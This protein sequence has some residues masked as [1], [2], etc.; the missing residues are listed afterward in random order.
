ML[1]PQ[2]LFTYVIMYFQNGNERKKE[3]AG[4]DTFQIN[5]QSSDETNNYYTQDKAKRKGADLSEFATEATHSALDKST[6]CKNALME[7]KAANAV[8]FHIPIEQSVCRPPPKRFCDRVKS[9][10]ENISIERLTE[11]QKNGRKKKES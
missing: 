10:R 2:L 6:A 9:E 5:K 11:K 3:T 7:I 1:F 4:Q 8:A